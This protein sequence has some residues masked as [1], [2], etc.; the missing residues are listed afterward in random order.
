MG[1]QINKSMGVENPRFGSTHSNSGSPSGITRSSVHGTTSPVV[2]SP[3]FSTPM[4]LSHTPN[5]QSSTTFVD[6]PFFGTSTTILMSIPMSVPMTIP[7]QSQTGPFVP[8]PQMTNPINPYMMPPLSSGMTSQI[9]YIIL[10][11]P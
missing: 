11:T 6:P 4:N 3:V 8:N 1:M 10:H 5:T 7:Y 9:S 2:S